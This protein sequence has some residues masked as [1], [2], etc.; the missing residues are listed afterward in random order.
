MVI[1]GLVLLVLAIVVLVFAFRAG[2]RDS[3]Y[4]PSA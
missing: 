1:A 2:E 3:Q 4:L